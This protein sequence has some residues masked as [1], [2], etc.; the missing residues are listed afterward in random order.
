MTNDK[1][2][3]KRPI[4]VHNHCQTTQ[5]ALNSEYARKIFSILIDNKISEEMIDYYKDFMYRLK[6]LHLSINEKIFVV[7]VM[8]S[9]I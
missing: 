1:I 3:L 6:I 4:L 5:E 7:D 2:D 9:F 8:N